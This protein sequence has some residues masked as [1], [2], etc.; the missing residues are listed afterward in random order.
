MLLNAGIKFAFFSRSVG[1]T[2]T[3][4]SYSKSSATSKG[5]NCPERGHAAA[6][7]LLVAAVIVQ[8]HPIAGD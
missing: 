3:P 4:W 8:P 1:P 5:W 7:D 6:T 2:F